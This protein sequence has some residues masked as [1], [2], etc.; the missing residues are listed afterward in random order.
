[1]KWSEVP[2]EYR[3]L[4]KTFDKQ[5]CL[6]DNKKDNLGV[7]FIWDETPQDIPFWIKCWGAKTIDQLP[8]I[9]KDA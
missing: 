3:D 1:M 5:K 8:P 7:R 2:Q 9:P 4:E 6:Y